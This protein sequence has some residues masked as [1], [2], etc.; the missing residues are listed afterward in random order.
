MDGQSTSLSANS[1]PDREEILRAAVGGLRV[2]QGFAHEPVMLD[3][4]LELFDAVPDGLLLDATIGG[5][6]HAGAILDRRPGI[7]ILGI[8]RDEEALEAAADRLVRFGPRVELHHGRFDD[9]DAILGGS[10]RPL[11][12]ALFDLGVSSHQ[13]DVAQRGFSY[14]L[15]GPLDMRMDRSGGRSAAEIVND[16]DERELAALFVANGES[17]FASRIARAIVAARPLARTD[18]LAAVV[19]RAIPAA[20]RRRGHPARRVFQALRIAVNDE[21]QVL[22]PALDAA[23]AHLV[24][25]GRIV[26]L[27]YHSGEDRLVKSRLVWAATGGCTCPP[28]L[29]CVCGAVATLRLLNRGARL[30]SREEIVRNPRAEAVRLRAA[31]R[32]ESS[33]PSAESR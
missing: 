32:L 31:E 26:V 30:A 8:D 12:G 25:G 15:A 3:A 28:G 33:A 14:R 9:L 20:A 7:A 18:E 17:R 5:G 23:I 16:E 11:V 19:E 27:S 21:L 4:V 2:N 22:E 13:L 1:H 24:P 29:P 6:G 10:D